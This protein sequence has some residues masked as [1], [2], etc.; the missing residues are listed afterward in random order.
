MKGMSRVKHLE[1][2]KLERSIQCLMVRMQATTARR[3]RVHGAVVRWRPPPRAGDDCVPWVAGVGRAF[4][5]RQPVLAM[6]FFYL[7]QS[8]RSHDGAYGDGR[9]QTTVGSET[10]DPV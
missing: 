6:F 4:Q 1:R 8:S 7:S 3:R 2:C 9:A 5:I 10:W